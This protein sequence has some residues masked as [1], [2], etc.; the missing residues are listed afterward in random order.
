M[1][2]FQVVAA[3]NNQKVNLSV[4]NTSIEEARTSLHLQ[5]YSIIEIKEGGENSERSQQ[6]KSQ[7]RLFY[8]LV[9]SGAESKKGQI[10]APDILRAYKKL[11]DGLSYTVESLYENMDSTEE[12]RAYVTAKAKEI[13][14][15]S[16]KHNKAIESTVEQF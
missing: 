15:E 7:N 14:L 11:S 10:Y 8:F 1:K 12:E 3:K 13:Y 4:E 2:L 9:K 16:N 5:G 6:L